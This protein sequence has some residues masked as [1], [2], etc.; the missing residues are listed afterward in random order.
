MSL[1]TT[2]P[3]LSLLHRLAIPLG[4]VLSELPGEQ[5]FGLLL[6]PTWTIRGKSNWINQLRDIWLSQKA[7]F[8][9]S[10]SWEALA[11]S[12]PCDPISQKDG[13]VWGR[14]WQ[15]RTLVVAPGL[16]SL[17]ALS[18]LC[19]PSAISARQ[20]YGIYLSRF[21]SC[22]Y[23]FSFTMEHYAPFGATSYTWQ[24][25][26]VII[27]PV[28]LSFFLNRD[29]SL[30]F[31]WSLPF[32]LV[33]DV[34]PPLCWRPRKFWTA[35]PFA[36]RDWCKVFKVKSVGFFQNRVYQK[37]D[38]FMLMSTLLST[39][40]LSK[41]NSLDLASLRFANI[42]ETTWKKNNK[43]FQQGQQCSYRLNFILC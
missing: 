13:L 14:C 3:Q 38:I 41:T 1:R 23:S 33:T 21:S 2:L 12:T 36:S 4:Q 20:L 28:F 40:K 39:A 43:R 32:L 5:P 11:F 7:P 6:K 37:Q 25:T 31:C 26:K 10:C 24:T 18:V 35:A 19:C 8:L 34:Q 16:S 42:L 9:L 29:R 27:C 22:N 15:D 30:F 17:K